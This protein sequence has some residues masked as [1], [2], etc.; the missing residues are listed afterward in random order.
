MWK[1]RIAAD[2]GELLETVIV[3]DRQQPVKI[4]LY[5]TKPLKDIPVAAIEHH[6]VGGF[7]HQHHHLVARCNV[8]CRRRDRRPVRSR[9]DVDF[10]F[11]DQALVQTNAGRGRALIVII[12]ERELAPEHATLR[13]DVRNAELIALERVMPAIGKDTAQRDRGAEC[14]R[15]ALRGCRPSPQTCRRGSGSNSPEKAFS[16]HAPRLAQSLDLS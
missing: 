5:R 7:R 3:R 10:V 14:D 15:I 4:R 16:L 11:V 8:C 9:H 2:Y 6:D 1:R 13:V 12:L